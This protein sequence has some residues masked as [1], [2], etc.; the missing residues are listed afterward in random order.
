MEDGP[1]SADME[2]ERGWHD[3]GNYRGITLLSQILKLLESILD[4]RIM[5]RVEGD[6]VEEQ[7]GFGKGR[8]TA[9][10]MYVPRQ[11]VEKRQ[12]GSVVNKTVSEVQPR[13]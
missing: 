13:P 5:R 7:Q 12:Y 10:G 2:E 4:A 6:L 9:D 1:D 11:M 8:G 3:P